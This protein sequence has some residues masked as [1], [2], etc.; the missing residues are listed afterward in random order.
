MAARTPLRQKTVPQ[1]NVAARP[2]TN[3]KPVDP[4]LVFGKGVKRKATADVV[5]LCTT[6]EKPGAKHSSPAVKRARLEPAP[7]VPALE[8]G[9]KSKARKEKDE[10]L[11]GD[12]SA[13]REQWQRKYRHAFRHFV[14]YFDG[15]DGAKR[16]EM[17]SILEELGSVR[18]DFLTVGL[19]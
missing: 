16:Q 10:A 9:K 6:S 13:N 17:A 3:R 5:D 7:A 2:S 4:A 8:R 12:V 15:I 1:A 19:C 14:F 11:R 18:L